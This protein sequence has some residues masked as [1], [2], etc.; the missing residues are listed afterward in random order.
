MQMKQNRQAEGQQRGNHQNG[1][2]T[3]IDEQGLPPKIRKLLRDVCCPGTQGNPETTEGQHR[4]REQT[5]GCNSQAAAP[6]IDGGSLLDRGRRCFRAQK[7]CLSANARNL[8]T[9]LA[10][11]GLY[12]AALLGSLRATSCLTGEHAGAA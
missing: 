2:N 3:Q 10:Y 4:Q 7:Q 12:F 5:E 1:K 6:A 11:E 9:R 8:F